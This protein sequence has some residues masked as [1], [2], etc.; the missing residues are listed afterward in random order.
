MRPIADGY[1]AQRTKAKDE[2]DRRLKLAVDS[3]SNYSEVVRSQ[4]D[5]VAFAALANM[6]NEIRQ[7]AVEA[8]TYLDLASIL[9]FIIFCIA[10]VKSISYTLLHVAYGKETFC[11]HIPQVQPLPGTPV[12]TRPGKDSRIDVTGPWSFWIRSGGSLDGARTSGFRLVGPPLFSLGKFLNP[13]SWRALDRSG[14]VCLNSFQPADK[15]FRPLVT[16]PPG[17]VAAH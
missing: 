6:K 11:K 4:S 8:L 17:L 10:V 15:W 13:W 14:S 9:G 5:A 7:Q 3:T 2:T 16:P 1:L 12:K